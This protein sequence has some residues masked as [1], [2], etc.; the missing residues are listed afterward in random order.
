MM[1]CRN[2]SCVLSLI[3]LGSYVPS[4]HMDVRIPAWRLKI[5]DL[6]LAMIASIINPSNLLEYLWNVSTIQRARAGSLVSDSNLRTLSLKSLLNSAQRPLLRYQSGQLQ[7]LFLAI[8]DYPCWCMH[9]GR[10]CFSR[11]TRNASLSEAGEILPS[12]NSHHSGLL[13]FIWEFWPFSAT[14][15]SQLG[16]GTQ[17]VYKPH[18][19]L[20]SHPFDSCHLSY[21]RISS[22]FLACV[23]EGLKVLRHPWNP[24]EADE[25][26]HRI[27]GPICFW[28]VGTSH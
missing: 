12:A 20:L 23:W 15:I 17:R 13:F 27:D 22:E 1:I 9:M 24:L 18:H 10:I 8:L 3:N 14:G 19:L 6:S 25:V 21:N 26:Q 5:L 7:Q 2:W 28:N 4:L 16:A 11:L